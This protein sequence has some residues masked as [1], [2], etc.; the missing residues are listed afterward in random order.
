MLP[1]D[2][3]KPIYMEMYEDLQKQSLT[4]VVENWTEYFANNVAFTMEIADKMK[5]EYKYE[6]LL[7]IY[8]LTKYR[9]FF[10]NRLSNLFALFENRND[11]NI[12]NNNINSTLST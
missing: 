10:V 11:K 8:S 6:S 3:N 7:H 9:Y 2:G 1:K 12:K 5:Q 4:Q